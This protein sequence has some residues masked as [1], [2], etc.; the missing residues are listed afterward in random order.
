MHNSKIAK[1]VDAF[2]GLHTRT[3]KFIVYGI[4]MFLILFSAG[5][6]LLL[7]NGTVFDFS[8]Y[9]RDISLLIIKNSFTILAEAVIGC[10][11]IDHIFEKSNAS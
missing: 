4:R 7:A 3:K 8:L 10:L 5:A 6:A 9:I 2:T 11:L 1:I